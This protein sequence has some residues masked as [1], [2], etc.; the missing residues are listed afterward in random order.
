MKVN[1]RKTILFLN[2]SKKF[3]SKFF[4]LFFLVFN[5]IEVIFFPIFRN[6]LVKKRANKNLIIFKN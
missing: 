6:Y 4:Q 3:Y 1:Y 5:F 2:F